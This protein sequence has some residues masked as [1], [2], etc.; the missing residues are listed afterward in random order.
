MFRK[1]FV[2]AAIVGAGVFVAKKVGSMGRGEEPVEYE[3]ESGAGFGEDSFG[4]S[5][6]A[7][8]GDQHAS[9]E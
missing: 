7:D 2:L 9:K 6:S 8:D 4:G 3:P 5:G 1:L